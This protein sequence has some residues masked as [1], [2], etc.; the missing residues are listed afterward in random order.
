MKVLFVHGFG[1]EDGGKMEHALAE[2]AATSEHTVLPFR[3]RSGNLKLMLGE[4]FG[5]ILG[6]TLSNVNPLRVS[7]RVL[8]AIQQSAQT[9]W[10][11]ALA[12]ITIANLTLLGSIR[13]FIKLDEDFSIIAFSLGAR[14][15]LMALQSLRD[16]PQP[17]RYVIFA[18]AAVS[19][20]A[21]GLIPT[22][23]RVPRGDRV[24]NVYS[25]EDY[26]LR[27]IYP[28]IHGC[29]DAAGINPVLS[30]GVKNLHVDVGHLSYPML[31]R[32]LFDLAVGG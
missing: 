30:E 11:N 7:A 13:R 18:G 4:G 17:L 26:V 16:D 5:N 1:G 12:H 8:L 22:T 32:L 25:D 27:D 9:H 19:R 15:T 2:C 10:D 24:I 20:A 6:E 14:V 31:A 28:L 29:G 23:L 3:W 21:F